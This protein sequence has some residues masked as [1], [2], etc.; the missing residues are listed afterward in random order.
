M[1]Q[2]TTK[3]KVQNILLTNETHFFFP[4]KIIKKKLRAF[5][6]DATNDPLQHLSSNISGIHFQ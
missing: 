5:D 4:G 3:F 1:H 6:T 2:I